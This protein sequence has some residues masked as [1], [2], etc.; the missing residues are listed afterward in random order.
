MVAWPWS[1]KSPDPSNRRAVAGST[2]SA[3]KNAVVRRCRWQQN[4]SPTPPA[5]R[6]WSC[7]TVRSSCSTPLPTVTVY[8]VGTGAVLT[9]PNWAVDARVAS[10]VQ[11][12]E[13]H[14][15]RARLAR[16]NDRGREFAHEPD[17][18]AVRRRGRTTELAGGR[19][20]ASGGGDDGVRRHA[21]AADHVGHQ[22]AAICW[23]LGA[24]AGMTA[25]VTRAD[26]R[27]D[28]P[29]TSEFTS[30]AVTE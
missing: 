4:P 14:G 30:N 10:H 25:L 20:R 2:T 28:G 17:H 9:T 19:R 6:V 23:L 21:V 16:L 13:P 12:V 7:G 24:G 5:D 27:L 1:R 15:E 22:V 26:S 8:S 18:A 29:E 3:S 11:A